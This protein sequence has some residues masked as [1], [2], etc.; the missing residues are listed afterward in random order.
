MHGTLRA[1]LAGLIWMALGL[2]PAAA[3]PEL[4]AHDLVVRDFAFRSG[5]SLPEL[6]LR[7]YTIGQP[8][9]DAAGRIDNAVLLL[10]GTGGTGR[11]FLAP[12][13]ADV[14]LTPGGLLDPATHF[15][16]IPDSIGHGGSSKPSDG[17]RTRFP[18]YDYADM[19]EAQHRV[20]ASLGVQR[21]R[22]VL[23]TSMGCMHAFMWG[24]AWPQEVQAMMPLACLPVEIAGRNRLARKLAIDAIRADP[25]WKGGDYVEPPL[26][27]LRTAAS[28]SVLTGSAVIPMQAEFPTR[29]A[30]D[31][32]VEREFP[33]RLAGVDANDQIY[34][35]DASRT[36][37]PSKDLGRITAAVT[38]VNS[39][40]DFSNPPEL[41]VAEREVARIRGGVFVLIPAGPDAHGHGTHS[42]AALWKDDLAALLAR[43]AQ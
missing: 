39:A 19:V 43:S 36:Y 18:H 37:D 32:W 6:R 1:A 28:L 16:I 29:A 12:Q 40:D 17:L 13:F 24:V 26:Q 42:W 27:G 9:R 22:L 14:L 2:A 3:A 15:I 35:L 41:R 4:A 10:H 11:A 5:D 30:A 34:A 8:H 38:W 21:L 23:G 33:R 25:A 7:Y 20:V 31:A